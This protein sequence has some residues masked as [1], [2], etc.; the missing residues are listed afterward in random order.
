MVAPAIAPSLT[1][2]FNESL[3]IGQFPSEWKEANINPVPKAGDKQDVNNYRSVSVMPVAHS[4][5]LQSLVHD[6]FYTYMETNKLLDPAQSGFRPHHCTQDVLAKSVDD[7]KIAL[8]EGKMVGTVLIDLSK[9]F[10][11]IN[12]TVLNKLY[13]Y[14]VRGVE[15]VWF[16]D[17]L[18]DRKQRVVMDGVSSDWNKVM[19]GV[20]QGLILFVVFVNDLSSVVRKCSVNLYVDDTTIYTSNEDPLLVGKKPRNYRYMDQQ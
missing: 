12:H 13:A 3:L 20:P 5:V 18:R 2:L 10:N 14:G 11:T 6:Q 1:S 4:E 9:A 7:W 17:Y 15:L 19:K 16:T 8:D